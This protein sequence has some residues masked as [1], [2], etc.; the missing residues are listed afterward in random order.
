MHLPAH[1]GQVDAALRAL[2]SV[3]GLPDLA[4]HGRELHEAAIAACS[5]SMEAD[6]ALGLLRAMQNRGL[7]VGLKPYNMVVTTLASC[8]RVAEAARLAEEMQRNGGL[9]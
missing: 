2:H 7:Q 9:A 5:M 4:Q 6:G 1:A 8:G 3:L